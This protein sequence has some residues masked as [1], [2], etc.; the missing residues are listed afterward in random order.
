MVE[1]L[2]D[3]LGHSKQNHSS[4]VV[5]CKTAMVEMVKRG[6]PSDRSWCCVK[7]FYRVPKC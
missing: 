6:S 3:F 4:Y 5:F 2:G 1:G 7:I